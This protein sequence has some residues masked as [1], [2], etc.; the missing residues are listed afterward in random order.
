MTKCSL[1]TS[2]SLWIAAGVCVLLFALLIVAVLA[3]DVQKVGPE[4][5]EIGLATLNI[6]VHAFFG[7]QAIWYDI[8]E[9]MGL[10]AIATA[11]GF[12]LLGLIQLVGRKSLAKVDSDL[13]CLAGLYVLMAI[14]YV[15]F[16]VVVINYRPVLTDGQLEASFPSSHTMLV[17][18][19]LASAIHQ[20]ANR[21]TSNFW[22]GFAVGLCSTFIAVTVMGR[23]ICGVHWF[24]DILGGVL[25]SAALVLAYLAACRMIRRN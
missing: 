17:I 7:E 23:L 11:G 12:A 10:L 5:S 24:T 6:A 21:L 16:E 2:R 1:R 25:L 9:V 15:V 18:V 4:G 3:I 22:R 19:I 20:L 14:A 8:T 13:Y